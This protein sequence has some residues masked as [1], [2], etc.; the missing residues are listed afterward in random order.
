[1]KKVVLLAIMAVT[2]LGTATAQY[3]QQ[4]QKLTP[5]QRTE[6]QMKRLDEKLQLSDSQKEEIKALFTD[7]FQQQSSSFK[8]QR[9]KREA[10]DKK[11]EALLTDDQKK[12]YSEMRKERRPMK[13]RG[14][15][16]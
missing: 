6:Q 3:P 5:E 16:Q 8:E 11:I 2:I 9:T 4:R 7:F 10:L 13:F 15:Q 14:K 1:M 12:I